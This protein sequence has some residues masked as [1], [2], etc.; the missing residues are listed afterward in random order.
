MAEFGDEQR[1]VLARGTDSFEFGADHFIWNDLPEWERVKQFSSESVSDFY[2]SRYLVTFREYDLYCKE[3]GLSLPDDQGWGRGRRPVV[4]IDWY[5]A[6]RYCNW[7]SKK[8]NL[9]AAYDEGNLVYYD[10]NNKKKLILTTT[11]LKPSA[12]AQVQGIRL[13][14]DI[15]WEYAAKGGQKAGKFKFIGGNNATDVAWFKENTNYSTQEVGLKKA[16]ELDLFDM[17]G[18]VY[19]YCTDGKI[20]VRFLRGGGW[21]SRPESMRASYSNGCRTDEAHSYVGFRVCVSAQ[22]PSQPS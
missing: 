4:N 9:P 2:I 5:E 19:E 16:N 14:C 6:T 21:S 15:E 3:S 18:N 13:P 20:N 10:A 8:R 11:R 22:R 12:L 1:W 7:L 17:C